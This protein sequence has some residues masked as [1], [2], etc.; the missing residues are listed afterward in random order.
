[1]PN[2][3]KLVMTQNSRDTALIYALTDIRVTQTMLSAIYAKL[4]ELTPQ[5][6]DLHL[7]E[8]QANELKRV[9]TL[10]ASIGDLEVPGLLDSVEH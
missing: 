5:E 1:M 7:K 8:M 2:G 4:F 9:Y 3:S 10:L 6:T